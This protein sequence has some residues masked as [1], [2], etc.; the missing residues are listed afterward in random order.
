VA[1]TVFAFGG[2]HPASL[3]V[4]GVA[5]LALAALHRPTVLANSPTRALD[6]GLLLLLG[7]T[8]VQLVPL[9]RSWLPLVSP[10][11]LAVERAFALAAP[12]GA[13]PLTISAQDS[14]AAV[15]LLGGLL[16]LF[17]TARATFARGGVRTAVRI[18]AVTGLVL[19]AVAL[20]QNATGK[21]LM[22]WRFAP[23]REGPA[24]FGPFVNRNHF[25]TWAMM[26]VP[27]CAG[28]LASHA[29]AHPHQRG[30][31]WRRRLLA[32]LDGRAWMLIA[33]AM[34]LIIATAASLSR[35]G[36]AGLSTAMICATVLV[37]RGATPHGGPPRRAA[38]YLGVL[39]VAGTLGVLIAV[40]PGAILGRFGASGVALADR[41]AIWHDTLPVLKDFWLS[42]TGVGTFQ[43]SMA[44][45]Q[46]SNPE[47][48]FNQAHNHYLQVAA[49]G[50]LLVGLPVGFA[51]LAFARAAWRSVSADRSAL[52]FIRAGAASGL[53][54]V[55]VQS[56]WE[57]GLTI[58]ANAVLASVLAAAIVHVPAR[59]PSAG[60]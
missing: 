51:L 56:F 15:V 52:Y 27:L 40:G 41:F 12:A 17:F 9:P 22:Y 31:D 25:A 34:L 50:G 58:P 44:I 6:A 49:E 11:A 19:A 4:P 26:A 47:V 21:G 1:W 54:G 32:V 10:A 57:T 59:G 38:A 37:R 33:A 18:I 30:A 23:G 28:Y 43:T 29:A 14:G 36:L 5:C 42:G 60:R 24:P 20:A 13:R 46:R 16:L 48:I 45:Y 39:G 55:A 8:L 2:I 3:V 35:S 53:A 7:A